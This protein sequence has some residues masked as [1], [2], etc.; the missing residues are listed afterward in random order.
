MELNKIHIITFNFICFF[1]PFV[2]W[3]PENWRVCTWLT[4]GAHILFPSDRAALEHRISAKRWPTAGPSLHM[5]SS[6][7]ANRG[8]GAKEEGARGWGGLATRFPPLQYL[9]SLS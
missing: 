4:L 8:E 7:P 6:G 3:L 5:K 2:M 9:M 1:L